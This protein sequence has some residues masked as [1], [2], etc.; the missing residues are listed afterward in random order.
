MQNIKPHHQLDKYKSYTHSTV[1][2][3]LIVIGIVMLIGI[4]SFP[5][6]LIFSI[7]FF[8]FAFI[9]YKRLKT[10]KSITIQNRSISL[11]KFVS[12]YKTQDIDITTINSIELI[13]ETKGDFSPNMAMATGDGDIE[14][15]S[16]YY[17]FYLKND[18]VIKFDN[19]Y[20]DKFQVNLKEWCLKNGIEI[21]LE[22]KKNK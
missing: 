20:D 12:G 7:L 16:N 1:A 9:S 11:G 15:H 2:G 19:L 14:I 4:S 18:K 13:H 6:N 3:V 5:K 22:V 10:T 17:L 8:G 21:N